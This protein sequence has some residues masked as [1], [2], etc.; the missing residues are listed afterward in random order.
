MRCPE[1]R[2]KSVVDSTRVAKDGRRRYRRCVN[3]HRFRTIEVYID[4]WERVKPILAL[5]EQKKGEDA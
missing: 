2:R 3:G 5:V 1:C 4:E